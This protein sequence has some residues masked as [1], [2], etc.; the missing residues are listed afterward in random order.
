METTTTI[1][2]H[3][4]TLS[5]RVEGKWKSRRRL[6]IRQVPCRASYPD[7]MHPQGDNLLP[8]RN[9]LR[10]AFRILVCHPVGAKVHPSSIAHHLHGDSRHRQRTTTT[11]LPSSLE[12]KRKSIRQTPQ[13]VINKINQTVLTELQIM[14][15]IDRTVLT[16]ATHLNRRLLE[17]HP[18]RGSRRMYQSISKGRD[19]RLFR[20]DKRQT[21]RTITYS[22][23]QAERSS[24][25][26]DEDKVKDHRPCMSTALLLAES[27]RAEGTHQESN[28]CL[29]S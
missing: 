24:R 5:R 16:E 19:H 6:R 9:F 11:T 20:L 21:W 10:V 13:I 3:P 1:T 15:K 7:E 4:T 18:P 25:H 8:Y 28:A 12:A 2:M 23:H 14:N 22:S 29:P 27:H 26:Q 17:N